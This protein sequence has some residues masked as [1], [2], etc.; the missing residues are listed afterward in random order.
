MK[1]IQIM[2]G[3]EEGGLEKHFVELCNGLSAYC[4]LV[5]MAHPKYKSRFAENITYESIDLTKGRN[6]PIILLQLLFLIQKH[7]ADIIHA[8]ANKAA[9]MLASLRYFLSGRTVATIHNIK[10]HLAFTKHFDLVVGVSNEVCNSIPST[11]KKTIYN[12]ITPQ[13]NV[14]LASLPEPAKR[15]HSPVVFAVGRLVPAKGFDILLKAWEQVD[16]TLLIAGDGPERQA[17]Q[18]MI[19]ASEHLHKRVQLLGHRDDISGIMSQAAFVVISSRN[20][21]FSYVFAESLLLNVPVISTDVPIPN[22][23]LPAEFI[24]SETTPDNLARL[25]N[26]SLAKGDSLKQEFA[27]IFKTAATSLTL[28]TMVKNTFLAYQ[29][30]V[31]Q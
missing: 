28:E 4:E 21:G 16:A 14:S 3:D 19:D 8:Q 20:E 17:L 23:I 6:N 27:A 26:I 11:K 12:G 25:I 13:K 2:A 31:D 29:D 9:S 10:K 15:N 5:V 30:L 24:A 1:V 7:K 22:E 18:R